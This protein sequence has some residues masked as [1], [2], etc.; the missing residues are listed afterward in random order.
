MH[1]L[2]KIVILSLFICC[3][4]MTFA[5]STD[6]A[7]LE[8]ALIPQSGSENKFSRFRFLGNIPFKLN[9]EGSYLVVGT[10]YR[11]HNVEINDPVPFNDPDGLDGL[12]TVGLELGYT[13]KMNKRWRFGAKFGTRI[14]SNFEDSGIQGDD[15]RYTGSFYFIKSSDHSLL[16]IKSRLILGV[17]YTTPASINF[18]LPI[19][20]YFK[21][22]DQNWSYSIGTPKSNIKYFFN[23]KNTLQLY[24]SLDRFYANIQNNRLVTV[25]GT[26]RLAENI[27]MLNVIGALGYEYYFTE[28]LLYYAYAGYTL[29]NRI[30][31]RDGD[32]DDVLILNDQNT[33]YFRS[34]IKIKI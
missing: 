12:H 6:L 5:Q 23:E 26:S 16:P 22:F 19:I 10:Q 2:R 21:R 32:Q 28:H 14:S 25:D 9:T 33:F 3:A 18:P 15:F 1:I 13:F 17:Q 30:R 31:L 4:G 7:R 11:Y 8:Y 34:G 27:S 20:N 29:L 24:V